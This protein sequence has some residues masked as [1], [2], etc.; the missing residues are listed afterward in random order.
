M[1]SKGILIVFL[2]ILV[3]SGLLFFWK[4]RSAP[5][6]NWDEGIHAE[7]SREMHQNGSWLSMTYRDQLYTA[8]PPLK[9][10]MTTALF[11]IFGVTEFAVRF[12][13]AIAGIATT[14][15]L[16]IWAWQWMHRY[17][18]VLVTVGSFLFSQL[19]FLHAFRTGETDGLL[20]FS[21]TAALYCYWRS[22]QQRRWFLWFGVFV[23]FAVMFKSIAGLLPP[24]IVGLDL[25]ISK[26]W[27]AL[28]LRTILQAVGIALLIIAPWHLYETFRH[29]MTFWRN[30]IGFHVL[31]R[32]V[33]NL[34]ANNVPWYWYADILFRK[35][36]PYKFLVP[37]GLLVSIARF[38][39]TREPLD[40]LLFVTIAIIFGAFTLVQ[41]KFAWYILPLLP[42][43]ALLIGRSAQEFFD[44]RKRWIDVVMLLGFLGT[45]YIL[46]TG[47]DRSRS[48][49]RILP[50]AYLPAWFSTTPFGRL[51][52][53]GAA[54]LLLILVIVWLRKVLLQPRLV[55]G[56]MIIGY[57]FLV[58]FGW[59]VAGIRAQ[60]TSAPL[61]R[62][63]QKL[64][65]EHATTLDVL[66][67]DL[68]RQPA[69]YFYLRRVS[70]LSLREVPNADTPSTDYLLTITA[71]DPTLLARYHILLRDGPYTLLSLR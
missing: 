19:V 37:I 42:A 32:S 38:V 2:I 17:T 4:L 20:A 3:I 21:I 45:A 68:L 60:A 15:L 5:L 12:W 8:K 51:A 14:L 44:D 47:I 70:G 35:T 18:T 53:A 50:H 31:D 54:L 63:A 27:R 26:R 46:P 23:G 69:G 30:Y 61:E 67:V 57:L 9:F 16:T 58:A 39:R 11:P 1:F 41:T 62:I 25:T 29:G 33:E 6:E 13:S 49:W 7:V 64:S 34:Y 66:G 65:T 36:Y 59:Q 28:G 48:L 22:R 71:L 24:I 55:I 10:W 56:G 52:V 43:L 40:R